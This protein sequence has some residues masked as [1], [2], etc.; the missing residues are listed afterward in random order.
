VNFTG[1]P[2]C[3]T[4]SQRSHRAGSCFWAE[5]IVSPSGVRRGP[6]LAF[7]CHIAVFHHS[8]EDILKPHKKLQLAQKRTRLLCS[9]AGHGVGT[10]VGDKQMR[11][12]IR[13]FARSARAATSHL[14]ELALIFFIQPKIWAQCTSLAP[15]VTISYEC[16]PHTCH[17]C[18]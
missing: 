11:G 15:R 9:I 3:S 7:F 5:F 12:V 13:V 1:A 8:N 17:A 4:P 6:R 16:I 18:I 2:R 10:P 14:A